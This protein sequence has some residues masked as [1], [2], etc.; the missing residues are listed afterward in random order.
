MHLC[1]RKNSND[2][3]EGSK[4]AKQ[5]GST[6][7]DRGDPISNTTPA[8]PNVLKISGE[9]FHDYYKH[10]ADCDDNAMKHGVCLKWHIGG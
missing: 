9:F 1:K 8:H 3:N 7:L 5:R 6:V 2:S 10:L 4:R